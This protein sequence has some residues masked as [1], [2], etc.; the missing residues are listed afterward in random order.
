MHE[1][2]KVSMAP[3]WR[4]PWS[5]KCWAA[6]FRCWQTEPGGGESSAS[7]GG[8]VSG[9]MPGRLELQGMDLFLHRHLGAFHVVCCLRAVALL[10][11]GVPR[12]G[13]PFIFL[14][15]RLQCGQ[16]ALVSME[17]WRAW[18]IGCAFQTVCGEDMRV[19]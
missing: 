13:R 12:C 7:F 3:T 9:D 16:A 11:N 2:E 6:A 8:S 19:V 17:T 14:G 1:T 4:H 10:Y 15:R 18:K 5:S